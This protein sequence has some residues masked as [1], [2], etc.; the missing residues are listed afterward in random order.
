MMDAANFRMDLDAF[1]AFRPLL[2][3]CG[4]YAAITGGRFTMADFQDCAEVQTPSADRAQ[5]YSA[6][7]ACKEIVLSFARAVKE[8]ESPEVVLESRQAYRLVMAES[9]RNGMKATFCHLQ[10]WPPAPDLLEGSPVED[11]DCAFEDMSCTLPAIAQKCFNED[12]RRTSNPLFAGLRRRDVTASFIVDFAADVGLQPATMPETQK[13]M[14]SD[15]ANRVEEWTKGQASQSSK[16]ARSAFLRGLGTNPA[17]H[18]LSDKAG[19]W[20]AEN[21]E[22]VAWTTA[23]VGGITALAL[24]LAMA[25]KRR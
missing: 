7:A 25:K 5:R 16:A 23:V 12:A 3:A 9:V 19:E 11:G 14:L 6:A 22:S 15:F 4:T 13:I 17:A 2:D 1:P 10:L 8:Q 21:W 24:G 18:L 20:W